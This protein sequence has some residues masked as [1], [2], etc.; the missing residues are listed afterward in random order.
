MKVYKVE[1]LGETTYFCFDGGKKDAKNWYVE[2]TMCDENEITSLVLFPKKDWKK[3]TIKYEDD[4]E[5]E[6]F[7]ITLEESMQGQIYPTILCSTA[8][9]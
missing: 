7:D 4:F 5:I 8:Y 1:E 3:V 2:E 6:P 9:V